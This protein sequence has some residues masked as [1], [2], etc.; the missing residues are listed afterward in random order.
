LGRLS[1]FDILVHWPRRAGVISLGNEHQSLWARAT[2]RLLFLVIDILEWLDWPYVPYP[3]YRLDT[4]RC[5]INKNDKPAIIM[6]STDWL[7]Y[8]RSLNG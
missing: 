8:K 4:G 7:E 5:L 6:I 2:T 3:E 1:A